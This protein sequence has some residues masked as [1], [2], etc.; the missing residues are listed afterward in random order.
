[1]EITARN[2]QKDQSKWILPDLSVGEAVQ[3]GNYWKRLLSKYRIIRNFLLSSSP[4]PCLLIVGGQRL[5][6]ASLELLTSLVG[7]CCFA[8]VKDLVVI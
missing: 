1:M 7:Q 2:K 3:N 4:C 5:P 8:A 6:T